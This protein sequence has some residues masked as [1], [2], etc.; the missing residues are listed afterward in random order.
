MPQQIVDPA[1]DTK[2]ATTLTAPPPA[3]WWGQIEYLT[4][5]DRMA[6]AHADR[7]AGIGP[8]SFFYLEHP[9]VITYGRSTPAGELHLG[10]PGIPRLEVP[11]GGLATYH[12][13]GQLVGYIILDLSRRA[14]GARPDIH[15]YLRA[16]ELGLISFLEA[17][18]DLPATLRDGYTGVWT[19]PSPAAESAHGRKLASIG[20]SARKWVTS[21]GFALNIHPDMTGFQAI[22]P[23]G[24]TDATMTSV[25]LELERNH[26]TF[27]PKPMEHYATHTHQHITAALQ[28][29][30][31]LS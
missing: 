24:I 31:W 25:K 29:E 7:V 26:R 6:T 15:A 2:I 27:T 5:L 10:A 23:C 1:A 19:M 4:A 30:G 12:A 21:H 20:V 8:D 13:P 16:I 3:Q 22:V 17:E 9:Q 28:S 14:A 18:F 11:R